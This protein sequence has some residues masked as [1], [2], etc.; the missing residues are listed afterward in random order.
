MRAPS[1]A[2]ARRP[3]YRVILRVLGYLAAALVLFL[4]FVVVLAS[5]PPPRG[6]PGEG[7]S[8]PAVKHLQANGLNFAYLEEGQGPLVLLLHGFPDNAHT[9]DDARRR[10]AENGYHAVAIYTR[11]YYP[12][13][14]APDADYS[15]ETMGKDALE[16]ISA[17][18]YKN[19]VIVGNDWGATTAYAAA[20][21]DPQ[22][23]SGIVVLGIPHPKVVSASPKV[24][25]MLPHFLWF[26]VGPLS[27]WQAGR[28]NFAYIEYLYHYWSPSWHVPDSLV[29]Q[30]KRDF[31][32]PGRLAASLRYYHAAIV[33]GFDSRKTTL[34]TATTTV[35]TLA[36][37]GE[38]DIMYKL[39][40]FTNMPS[41]FTGPF[42]LVPVPNTGHFI[43]QEQPELFADKLL[44]FLKTLHF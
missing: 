30:M 27:T 3:A 18:G 42:Q 39:G 33:D 4:V 43:Q 13:D 10:L 29:A 14:L 7:A 5:Y 25:Y 17:L 6:V 44:A 40:M 1:Y 20:N 15:V 12:T 23:V 24:L 32:R 38:Q 2:R 41:A 11:G 36:M 28:N 9:W 21:L 8:D 16:L 19:G 31:S 26:Q 37:V 22:K 35:P 34:Y